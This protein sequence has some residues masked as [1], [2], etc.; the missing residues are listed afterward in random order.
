MLGGSFLQGPL[1][2]FCYYW[3]PNWLLISIRYSMYIMGI[4]DVSRELVYPITSKRLELKMIMLISRVILHSF[5][6]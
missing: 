3:G 5:Q 2:G 1:G 6:P 4:V